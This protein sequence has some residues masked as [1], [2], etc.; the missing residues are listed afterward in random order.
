MKVVDW[1]AQGLEVPP[2]SSARI[3]AEADAAFREYADLVG[4]ETLAPIEVEDIAV[5][6]LKLSVGFDNVKDSFD[7]PVRGAIWFSRCEI[8]IDEELHPSFNSELL[9]PFFLT[10]AHEL[11][12]WVLHRHLLMDQDG[13]PTLFFGCDSHLIP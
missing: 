13:N 7:D 4:E 1:L 2:L 3:A 12:H 10:L 8:W 11:D 9:H 5:S 6:L